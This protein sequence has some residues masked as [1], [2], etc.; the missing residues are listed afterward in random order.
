[1][2]LPVPVVTGGLPRNGKRDSR[3]Y[4][5]FPVSIRYSPPFAFA[6]SA[7]NASQ[8]LTKNHSRMECTV[9]NRKTNLKLRSSTASFHMLFAAVIV[10]VFCTRSAAAPGPTLIEFCHAGDDGLS[11]RLADEVDKALSRSSD[12]IVSSGRKPST[13]IVTIPTN[14]DWKQID[15]QTRAFYKVEFSS[16][17]GRNLGSYKGSCWDGDLASVPA[18]S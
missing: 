17:D 7:F 16:T 3:R 2:C 15:K 10:S 8:R 9:E 13:L 4:A 5:R 1:M 14:V 6:K 11:Q 12:F 18:R